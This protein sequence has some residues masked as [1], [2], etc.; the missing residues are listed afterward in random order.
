M[1]VLTELTVICALLLAG[2]GGG[3]RSGISE[4]GLADWC[5][6]PF[7]PAASVPAVEVD[8][9]RQTALVGTA[10]TFNAVTANLTNPGF[11]WCRFPSAGESCVAISSAVGSSFTI[12]SVA[13]ADDGALFQV[14]ATGPEGVATSTFAVVNV[15]SMPGV[16]YQDGEFEEA[17]WAVSAT[18]APAQ[19]GPVFTAAR[20]VEGGH[21]GPFRKATY[22]FPTKQKGSVRI[23]HSRLSAIYS[24][25]SQGAIHV[26]DFAEDTETTSLSFAPST[27]PLLEQSG[28]RFMAPG[29]ATGHLAGRWRSRRHPSLTPEAFKLVDGPACGA[30]ESCPDFSSAGAPIRLGLVG[31]AELT[32]DLPST[33]AV[34]AH[35]AHGFDNWTATVW[36]K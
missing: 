17:G 11:V 32:S 20:A 27:V 1:K 34:P 7:P 3:G 12:A 4:C 15:S 5:N 35:F 30:N 10:V 6:A 33:V 16:V 26:I 18:V 36:R 14:T 29:F 23:F 2:C 9:Y 21:P 19:N 22:D 24:P 28:R 13:L 31:V 8:P 25:A